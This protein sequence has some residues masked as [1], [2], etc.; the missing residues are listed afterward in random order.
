MSEARTAK[1]ARPKPRAEA[2]PPR[3]AGL[4]ADAGLLVA[5]LALTFLLGAFPLKDTDFWWHLR[6]GDWIRQ[7]GHP[8]IRDLYTCTVPDNYWVDLHWGFEVLLSWG[9]QAFGVVGLNLA[10][11]GITCAAVLLLVTARRRD[12]PLGVM[13]L[14]WLPAL[15]VLAGRMYVRPETLTLLYLAVFLAV[16]SRWD[17]YPAPAFVLPVVQV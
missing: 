7:H 8:P 10:K 16:L 5:F 9:Y 14:A 15:G 3:M 13:L 12:W 17:R 11:C 4:L 6:T 2:S 1:P